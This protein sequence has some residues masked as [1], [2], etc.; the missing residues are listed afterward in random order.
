VLE[1]NNGVVIV[2][3]GICAGNLGT[4]YRKET[5]LEDRIILEIILE[6]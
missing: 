4:A 3:R 6:T 2:T 5:V 1:S